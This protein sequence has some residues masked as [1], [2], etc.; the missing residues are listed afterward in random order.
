M[1]IIEQIA[2][3]SLGQFNSLLVILDR[4]SIVMKL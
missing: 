3:L 4:V 1:N 2:D